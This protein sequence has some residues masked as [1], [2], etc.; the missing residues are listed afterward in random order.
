MTSASN[1]NVKGDVWACVCKCQALGADKINRRREGTSQLRKELRKMSFRGVCAIFWSPARGNI[2]T[3]AIVVRARAVEFFSSVVIIVMFHYFTHGEEVKGCIFFAYHSQC[4][5][6]YGIEQSC[7][8][9]R[10]VLVCQCLRVYA[11]HLVYA[12]LAVSVWQVYVVCLCVMSAS[13][14]HSQLIYEFKCAAYPLTSMH[15]CG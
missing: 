14:V 7:L 11:K 10:T 3:S 1:A 12:A 4:V 9:Y 15:M 8:S 13:R 5:E 6:I 2:V